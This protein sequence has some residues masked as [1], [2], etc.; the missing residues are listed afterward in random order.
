M[1]DGVWPLEEVRAA[2]TSVDF[3]RLVLDQI[4]AD[5]G[6]PAAVVEVGD[7]PADD[8]GAVLAGLP[9]VS[10]AVGAGGRSWDLV[11]DDPGAA[12][13]GLRANPQ[14]AVVAA[15]TLRRTER[16]GLEAERVGERIRPIR[17]RPWPERPVSA[18][19]KSGRHPAATWPGCAY[20]RTL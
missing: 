7:D 13:A 5:A 16:L 12:L 6:A 18:A 10:V 19:N 20:P 9:V 15:Q 17:A 2:A 4:A 11:L 8:V 14:A 1:S 3:D